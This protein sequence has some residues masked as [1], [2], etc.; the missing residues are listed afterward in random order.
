MR[1]Q[2]WALLCVHFCTVQFNLSYFRNNREGQSEY[3]CCKY[4][5]EKK[6]QIAPHSWLVT[7][8]YSAGKSRRCHIFTCNVWWWKWGNI[9]EL[10]QAGWCHQPG[11]RPG[12]AFLTNMHRDLLL[13]YVHHFHF[14][15]ALG[16]NGFLSPPH[17]PKPNFIPPQ[18]ASCQELSCSAICR[19]SPS[20]Y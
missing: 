15:S 12:S 7:A 11:T 1:S 6:Q 9:R 18:A 4:S 2:S 3:V 16:A 10:L 20:D 13:P 8:A 17:P 19:F 5:R 14:Q